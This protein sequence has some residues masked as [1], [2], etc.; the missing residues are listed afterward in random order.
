MVS[1]SNSYGCFEC[2]TNKISPIGIAIIKLTDL[3]SLT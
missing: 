2:I 3:T 1:L